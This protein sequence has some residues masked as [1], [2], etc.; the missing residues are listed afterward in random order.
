[1][2]SKIAEKFS[3][4]LLK[5]YLDTSWRRSTIAKVANAAHTF[6]KT[7]VVFLAKR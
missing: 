5:K 6:F 2:H 1:M 4:I 7:E 3:A